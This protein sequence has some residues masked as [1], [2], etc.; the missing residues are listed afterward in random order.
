MFWSCWLQP[1]GLAE[2][3]LRKLASRRLSRAQPPAR[4]AVPIGSSAGLCP[5]SFTFSPEPSL[6]VNR[7]SFRGFNPHLHADEPYLHLKGRAHPH[8]KARASWTNCLQ[9]SPSGRHPKSKLPKL[10]SPQNL[11]A[12]Q[13]FLFQLVASLSTQSPK[14]RNLGGHL[15]LLPP[16]AH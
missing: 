6:L 5:R 13:Y 12:Y 14:T 11:C 1:R 9:P 15:M 7:P 10:N 8:P 16:T 2:L 3:V 4:P